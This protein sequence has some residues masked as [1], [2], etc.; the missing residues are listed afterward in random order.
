M[1]VLGMLHYQNGQRRAEFR[2]FHKQ[3]STAS[4]DHFSSKRMQPGSFR[5]DV[6]RETTSHCY[7]DHNTDPTGW[8]ELC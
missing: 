8:E 1:P 3:D 6:R 4:P 2:R 7:S 5:A